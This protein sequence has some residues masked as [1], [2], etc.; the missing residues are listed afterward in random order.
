MNTKLNPD[1]ITQLLNLSARQLDQQT[2]SR[3]NQARQAALGRQRV[4]V[5]V[6]GLSTGRWSHGLFPHTV[7]PW[8]AAVL[9]AVIVFS[10]AG[11]WHNVQEQQINDL[12]VAI[13]TDELPL[14]VF[15][16]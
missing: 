1:K 10:G 4:H 8:L 16:D 6:F 2:L 9:L 7:Q 15:V 14:E 5:P 3:L 11:Y 12:D 13:L